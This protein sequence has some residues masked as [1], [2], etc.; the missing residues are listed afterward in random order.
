MKNLCLFSIFIMT[1][2]LEKLKCHVTPGMGD[3]EQCRNMTHGGGKAKICQRSVTF[4]LNC[5]EVAFM[6]LMPSSILRLK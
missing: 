3:T 2:F 6:F 5:P 1:L 4:Y